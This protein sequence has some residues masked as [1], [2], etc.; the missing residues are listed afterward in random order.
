MPSWPLVVAL[1]WLSAFWI[2][3]LVGIFGAPRPWRALHGV[4]DDGIH[5]RDK[6]L[7]SRLRNPHLIRRV[8]SESTAEVA[9]GMSNR[10]VERG[11][12]D[13]GCYGAIVLERIQL[14]EVRRRQFGD[15][16][17]GVAEVHPRHAHRQGNEPEALHDITHPGCSVDGSR[18]A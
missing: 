14:G 4:G 6:P 9:D 5:Y 11:I 3:G 2:V 8:G 16:S 1:A 15:R 10:R 13:S 12:A 17:V 7:G 18:P